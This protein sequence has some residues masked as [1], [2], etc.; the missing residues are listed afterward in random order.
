MFPKAK[1]LPWLL[2]C[3][4]FPVVVFAEKGE[5]CMKRGFWRIL[6]GAVAEEGMCVSSGRENQMGKYSADF[7]FLERPGCGIKPEHHPNMAPQHFEGHKIV[8]AH[9]INEE[10]TVPGG[11]RMG[12]MVKS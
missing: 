11:Q 9:A 12:I 6:F 4:G 5:V 3:G 2:P 1:R 8:K 7:L 10:K